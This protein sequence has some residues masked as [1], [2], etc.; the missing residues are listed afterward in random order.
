MDWRLNVKIFVGLM[1]YF[2]WWLVMAAAKLIRAT[3]SV[4]YSGHVTTLHSLSPHQGQTGNITQQQKLL[5]GIISTF[6]FHL[7]ANGKYTGSQCSVQI[8]SSL[9]HILFAMDEDV[10]SSCSASHHKPAEIEIW[11]KDNL[12]WLEE[13]EQPIPAFWYGA[14]LI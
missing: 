3:F 5:I 11:E 12:Q 4:T 10:V 1:F 6:C 13:E 7:S 8:D 14:N 2:H 9:L